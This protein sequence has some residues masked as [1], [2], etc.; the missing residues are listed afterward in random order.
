VRRET[1]LRD[2]RGGPFSSLDAVLGQESVAALKRQ[3]GKK[4]VIPF[5]GAGMS[6]PFGYP[7][8]RVFLESEAA[9]KQRAEIRQRLNAGEYEEVAEL[10]EKTVP[11]F[12]DHV[13][14]T[15][16][17]VP[18]RSEFE[19]LFPVE[20]LPTLFPSSPV[21]TTNYDRVLEE[22]YK[23]DFKPFEPI[24]GS[25]LQVLEFRQHVLIKLHGDFSDDFSTVLTLAEYRHHYGKADEGFS[26]GLPLP[27]ALL[28]LFRTE[29]VLFLGCSMRNDRYLRV[30][31]HSGTST[32][33]Y[34]FIPYESNDRRS[35]LFKACNIRPIQYDPLDNHRFVD[36]VLSYLGDEITNRPASNVTI[37][38][39]PGD[40]LLSKIASELRIPRTGRPGLDATAFARAIRFISAGRSA[41]LR[42]VKSTNGVQLQSYPKLRVPG[43]LDERSAIVLNQP[44]GAIMVYDFLPNTKQPIQVT[45]EPGSPSSIL[46]QDK[47]SR[48]S[49]RV[50][51]LAP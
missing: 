7:G 39:T 41:E 17:K 18:C 22:V 24:T 6:T 19:F 45:V 37:S 15:F 49:I 26:T 9:L 46:F 44:A 29:S 32:T 8:W 38:A 43:T 27:E 16:G 51:V 36:E 50:N 4:G 2:G 13:K 35:N 11:F 47:S 10:L 20:R 40:E 1:Y 48:I 34:A 31:K 28:H 30:M 23:N 5:V 33:H 25:I 3:I 21:F 12:R 14:T 42:I